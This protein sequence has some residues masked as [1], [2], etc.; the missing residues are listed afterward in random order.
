MSE[1]LHT[2]GRLIAFTK[3][4]RVLYFAGMFLAAGQG[5]IQTVVFGMGI[6]W[7]LSAAQSGD[8]AH[9]MRVGIAV[10]ALSVFLVVIYTL[11]AWMLDHGV[12]RISAR[13]R[14]R[15]EDHMVK[16]PAPWY[17][18]QHSGDVM[19]RL[20]HDYEAGMEN[21]LNV[22]I[23]LTLNILLS[24]V[25]S[26]IAIVALDWRIALSLLVISALS[27]LLTSRFVVASRAAATD[28]RKQNS[29]VSE[30]LLDIVGAAQVLHVHALYNFVLNLLG[31]EVKKGREYA[32]R[33]GRI[34]ALQ[35]AAG[36]AVT[37]LIYAG[38]LSVG[39]AGMVNGSVN[40]A[41][42]IAIFQLSRGPI[43]LFTSFGSMLVDLQNGLA[44]AERVFQMWDI[45]EENYG[46]IAAPMPGAPAVSLSG[47]NFS[48]RA[49]TPI[50]SGISLEAHVGSKT[51]LMGESGCG[52]S[53]VMKLLSGLYPAYEGSVKVFG[54]ELRELPRNAVNNLLVYVTQDPHL[55]IGTIEE[56]IGL[57]KK[58]ASIEEIKKAAELADAHEFIENLPG[59]Y[60]YMISERGG[61]QAVRCSWRHTGRRCC[62]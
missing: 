29:A 5:L 38:V 13:A 26:I 16:I 60:G 42:L 52:K 57:A 11:G 62:R 48:Y 44:G 55:F 34:I 14:K 24:G 22:P 30:R 56:N 8:M 33:Q 2:L 28:V 47:V 35:D 53:T 32:D 3:G 54:H 7:I 15:L 10:L 20:F 61:G 18:Q 58:G 49:D 6:Y 25:G 39:L 4:D 46:H 21:T 40:A 51:A 12:V 59:G 19:T 36:E 50:L 9:T 27:M 45:T 1:S 31:A 37:L 17:D 41:K 23:Q 43:N